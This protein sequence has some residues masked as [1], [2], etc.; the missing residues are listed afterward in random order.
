MNRVESDLTHD[1]KHARAHV[2]GRL[3]QLVAELMLLRA[4]LDENDFY[5]IVNR[6]GYCQVQ[7]NGIRENAKWLVDDLAG[8]HVRDG[9]NLF[10]DAPLADSVEVRREEGQG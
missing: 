9:K 5:Q 4:D 2:L 7:L 6:T 1:Q 10:T 3:E 8:V